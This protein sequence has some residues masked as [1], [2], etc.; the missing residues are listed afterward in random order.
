MKILCIGDI[1]GRPGR[2]VLRELLPELRRRH[3]IDFVVGNAENAAGGFGL[4]AEVLN[5]LLQLGVDAL[6][7]GNHIWDRK[8]SI[9]ILERS[10][11]VLR[12]L[13]YPPGVP[14]RGFTVFP[15]TGGVR[16]GVL[17]L[18]GRVFMSALDCPF[19]AADAA[20]ERLREQT[21][22]IVVDF[23]A[24]ATSEKV[25]LARYLDGRVTVVFGTHTHVQTAD[26]RIQAGGTAAVTDAGMTGGHDSV[27]GMQ[28]APS[29]R[30]F[31][32]QLPVKFEP[33]K[34]GLRL[35]ALLVE[36]DPST[37]KALTATRL[38]LPLDPH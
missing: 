34:N 31:L 11:R 10:E 3:G 35:N 22:V 30:R 5:D 18:E 4:T 38:N 25:A 37:G 24:E 26:E 23:H 2:R 29:V 6:T 27:I 13:N 1:I 36:A 33:E 17:N 7:T 16:V 12:P 9:P 21:P 8:E 28:P 15:T 20:L 19:R 14:G 32:T